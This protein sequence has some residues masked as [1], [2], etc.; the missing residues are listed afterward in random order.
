MAERLVKA[1]GIDV[2]T[3]AFGDPGDPP[4]LLIMGAGAQGLLWPDGFCERLVV[5]HRY[6]I[7][8]DHRDTGQSSFFDFTNEP[9]SLS[10]LARDAVG[11]L[12]A[13]GLR[14]AH[15]VGASMGGMI[16]QIL[17]IEHAQR[18][19]SLVSIMSTPGGGELAST[20]V[21]GETP[22]SSLPSPSPEFIAKL[23][24]LLQ[25]PPKTR[26][27]RIERRL[28]IFR[29]TAGSLAP[30]EE[31][32]LRELMERE[33]DR[34]RNYLAKENHR[35]AVAA[36]P[37]RR[38]ALAGVHLPVLVIHGTEDPICPY[39]HGVATA[40]AIPGAGLM[41]IE[42]MGHELPSAVWPRIAD[43][44]LEHTATAATRHPEQ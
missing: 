25:N 34:A 39:E 11:I 26:E 16:G 6:V 3:E 23:K 41:P 37:D 28:H 33:H 19:L 4:V 8:Y 9:Y 40:G 29:I 43:A 5:G 14:R 17:A 38:P 35:L 13:Y 36:E 10:D 27:E 2:W 7:R 20:V 30:F 12:D 21:E 22:A 24:S 42:K 1:N 44:I 18:I 32:R 15:V 31:N